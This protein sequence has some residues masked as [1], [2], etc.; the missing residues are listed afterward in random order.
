MKRFIY[1]L[2]VITMLA[3]LLVSCSKES[4]PTPVTPATGSVNLRIK[5]K[6]IVTPTRSVKSTAAAIPGSGISM[7]WGAPASAVTRQGSLFQADEEAVYDLLLVQI[8]F[9]Y[10][11]LT[12]TEMYQIIGTPAYYT[13]D[14][15]DPDF[16]FVYNSTDECYELNYE[17][18]NVE[19]GVLVIA[20]LGN[21][22][23]LDVG[24]TYSNTEFFKK[25]LV[26]YDSEE[27]VVSD[28]II[29]TGA[30]D[31]YK[32]DFFDEIYIGRVV[33]KIEFTLNYESEVDTGDDPYNLDIYSVQL[34]NVPKMGGLIELAYEDLEDGNYVFPP[35][36]PYDRD[37]GAPDFSQI[38]PHSDAS[39]L[40]MDYAAMTNGVS[41]ITSGSTYTWYMPEHW[42]GY[43]DYIGGDQHLKYWKN[44]PSYQETF[45]A[46]GTGVS[47]AT[48]IE[49][50][51]KYTYAG[52]KQK[53]V[54]I[55]IY[56]GTDN[57]KSS[58]TPHYGSF[59]LYRNWWYN[60][61][62]NI[63]YIDPSDPRIDLPGQDK[64][65]DADVYPGDWDENGDVD[66]EFNNPSEL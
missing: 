11:S 46:T 35:V 13:V 60:F 37:S 10:N 16:R 65:T 6:Q 39:E 24:A 7:G 57:D 43:A 15:A 20:N 53:D 36:A 28:R 52:G 42:R 31:I 62:V 45:Y 22:A 17:Y 30:A 40:F 66:F 56:P 51:G 54:M 44:D 38:F 50:K 64:D 4:E 5:A 1:I 2:T 32:D 8:G 27:D 12:E 59:E 21:P 34:R 33:S 26:T 47:Y 61:H 55:T 19:S 25:M 58:A 23:L 14:N 49:I 9:Q 18:S 63:N 3:M 29:M 41:P 48:R